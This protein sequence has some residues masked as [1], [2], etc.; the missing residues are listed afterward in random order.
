MLF[1]GLWPISFLVWFDLSVPG[2]LCCKH[3]L[4]ASPI[5]LPALCCDLKQ[6]SSGACPLGKSLIWPPR[7]THYG[8]PL[9]LLS[10]YPTE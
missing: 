3:W 4:T 9:A 5:A 2:A 1:L 6:C 10:I 7:G 8:P